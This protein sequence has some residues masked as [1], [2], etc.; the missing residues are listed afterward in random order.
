LRGLDHLMMASLDTL[1]TMHHNN[2][3]AA[4]ERSLCRL[5]HIGASG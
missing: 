5:P 2:A 1:S 4:I 3:S